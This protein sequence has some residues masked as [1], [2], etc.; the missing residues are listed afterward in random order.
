MRILSFI[1]WA[2]LLYLLGGSTED[3]P[4]G[5]DF[6]INCGVCH[7]SNGWELDKS[8]YSFN[9]SNTKMSLS[10]QH[11]QI[12]CRLCHP[13]LVFAE[14]K[15][16]TECINCHTDIHNQTVGNFCDKCHTPASWL[17]NNITEIHQQT[18]FPLLGVHTMT[19]CQK[20]HQSESLHRY[21]VKGV[22]CISCHRANYMSTTSPNHSS[23]NI[24]TDCSQCHNIYA[25]SWTGAGFN[26]NGFPLTLGHSNVECSKCHLNNKFINTSTEC[27]SCHKGDYNSTTQ[28]VHTGGC[29]STNCTLCHTTNPGWKPVTFVHDNNF[30]L[31]LG[32]NNVQCS[33][34][35]VSSNCNISSECYSC[36]KNDYNAT[37]NPVHT[38][39]CYSKDCLKC[40]T[41]NPSWKPSSFQHQNYFPINSGKHSGFTCNQCHT[42]P[43]NCTYSCID[44]H[45][46]SQSSMNSK[47]NG[48]SGYSWVSSK[49]YFCHPNGQAD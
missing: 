32:H 29:F 22:E 34:C 5:K 26:H 10:G 40:H 23:S 41:T 15:S 42:N 7:S 28:P 1:I 18:R 12:N 43:A 11:N 38:S 30:P 8:I 21:D 33:K 31:T 17:V 25:Y 3:S 47:H 37:T 6:T 36:H 39:G 35:H 2:F 48:V 49:C 27:Y 14:A 24:S 9:H 13:T 16:K 44:C 46:H 45:D 4:H 20:C 19:E